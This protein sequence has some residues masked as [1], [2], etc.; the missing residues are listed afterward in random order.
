MGYER[1]QPSNR[2]I[3]AIAV[4]SV[5]V[6]LALHPLLTSFFNSSI[7]GEEAVKVRALPPQAYANLKRAQL[8]QLEQGTMPIGQAMGVV[9]QGPRRGLPHVE[10][11]PGNDPAPAAG[12]AFARGY[13]APPASLDAGPTAD[14]GT[15]GGAAP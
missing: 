5:A 11:R 9:A 7:A 4:A 6:L 13:H 2:I 3:F 12:W 14:A 1:S 8:R 15:S 10:P